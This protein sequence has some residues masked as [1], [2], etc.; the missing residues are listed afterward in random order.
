MASELASVMRVFPQTMVNITVSAEGKALLDT[1]ADI[2]AAIEAAAAKLGDAGRILVRAS[3]TEPL[4]RVM[5]EGP[6]QAEIEDLAGRVADIIRE[7]TETC[8]Q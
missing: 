1:D 5:V 4:V 3:G 8:G 7:R 2:Q 6:D